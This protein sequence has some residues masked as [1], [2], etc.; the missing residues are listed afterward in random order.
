[1]STGFLIVTTL[2]R[3][4]F[5]DPYQR[6]GEILSSLHEFGAVEL[7]TKCRQKSGRRDY[8]QAKITSLSALKAVKLH[9]RLKV[10]IY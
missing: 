4:S 9:P 7:S 8:R 3:A 1:M 10:D 5:S 6:Q 2:L